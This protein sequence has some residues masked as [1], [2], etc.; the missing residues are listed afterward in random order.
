LIKTGLAISW[1]NPLY[2]LQI[3]SR[4]GLSYKNNVVTEAGVIDFDYLKEIGVILQNNSDVEFLV[5]N[6]SRIAQ[7]T[8]LKIANVT[9]EEV[10][11]FTDHISSDRTGGY[12]S[13][14]N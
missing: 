3:L 11:E 7:Y 8:F 9:T 2:Y 12:G 6:G 14:G 10:E 5:E 1:D 4:S 13:T